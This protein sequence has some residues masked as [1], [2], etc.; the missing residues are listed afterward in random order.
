MKYNHIELPNNI[1]GFECIEVYDYEKTNVWRINPDTKTKHP[2]PYPESLVDKLVK[3]YSFVGDTILDPFIGSGTTTISAYKLNRKSIGFEIH[4]EYIKLFEDRIKTIKKHSINTELLIDKKDYIGLSE[5]EIKNN[6]EK[7]SKKHLYQLLF[8]D[9][10]YKNYSK[11]ELV[12]T[13]YSLN[14]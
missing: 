5:I 9:N 14:F 3:Y 6:L 11:A 1:A 10:K 12:N 4:K 7:L 13:I 2:A 8:N